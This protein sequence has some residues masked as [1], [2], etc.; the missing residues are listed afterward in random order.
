[1]I[2]PHRPR[3][4]LGLIQFNQSGAQGQATWINK[5]SIFESAPPF[6]RSRFECFGVKVSQVFRK[7]LV[8]SQP[9]FFIDNQSYIRS[10][11]TDHP[12][13]WSSLREQE[14]H[15]SVPKHRALFCLKIMWTRVLSLSLPTNW[16]ADYGCSLFEVNQS[17]CAPIKQS[18]LESVLLSVQIHCDLPPAHSPTVYHI[19]CP[20]WAH[21]SPTYHIFVISIP[22]APPASRLHQGEFLYFSWLNPPS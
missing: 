12:S 21:Q 2:L 1:M 3:E 8:S 17:D 13:P 9:L 11:R 18:N 10:V 4:L 19:Q 22:S 20:G 14:F 5:K 15:P 7:P 16:S 6:I